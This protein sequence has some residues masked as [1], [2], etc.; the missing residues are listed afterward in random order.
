MAD[1]NR[2]AEAEVLRHN[3]ALFDG[4]DG[5]NEN[6]HLWTLIRGMFDAPNRGYDFD[7]PDSFIA[8]VLLTAADDF[9][10]IESASE[11]SEVVERTALRAGWRLRIAMELNRRYR[12]AALHRSKNAKLVE[13][14]IGGD[15]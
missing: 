9:D 4:G 8:D 6:A 14:P 1:R 5:I 3:D 12:A 7:D 11:S 10:L 13:I 15:S 2:K